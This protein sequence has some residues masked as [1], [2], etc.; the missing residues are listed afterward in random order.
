MK[1]LVLGLL[2][3]AAIPAFA[4]DWELK[5]KTDAMTDAVSKEASVTSPDGDRFTILRRGDGSAWG[6]VQLAGSNMFGISDTLIVRVDKNKPVEF[7]DK[8]EK[9][10]IKLKMPTMNMWEWNP[11][12]IGFRIW[13][14]KQEEG[15]GLIKELYDGQQIIVRY[16]P[17][18]STQ[19]DITFPLT[20][21][22]QALS[23]ALG[24]D[25]AA[26]PPKAE[27]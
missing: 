22:N 1:R 18:Q 9:L 10:A 16:H 6:Y 2:A 23:D 4:G 27:K 19:R 17:N 12:L 7:S 8:F 25:V 24:I 5:S 20:G 14:G 15:C 13:H 3:C 11:S 21:N 26:C